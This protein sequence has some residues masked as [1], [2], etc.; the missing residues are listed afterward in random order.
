MHVNCIGLIIIC[1]VFLVMNY[2]MGKIRYVEC[3]SAS[4][5]ALILFKKLFPSHRKKEIET[6]L[7]KAVKY[8]EETQKEDGSWYGN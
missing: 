6:F 3:T 7:S 2:G 1:F 4:I 5:Q 8:L